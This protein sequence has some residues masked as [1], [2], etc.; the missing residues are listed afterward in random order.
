MFGFSFSQP[1][2]KLTYLEDINGCDK[3]DM[4]IS[5]IDDIE[6]MGN[7]LPDVKKSFVLLDFD[8]YDD[9]KLYAKMKVPLQL[10][11][12]QMSALFEHNLSRVPP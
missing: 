4:P 6:V 12:V 5:A 10:E 2:V 1:I 11:N 7:Y 3:M 9:G 8:G